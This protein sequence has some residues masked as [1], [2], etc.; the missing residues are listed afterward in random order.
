MKEENIFKVILNDILIWHI[1]KNINF[2][3]LITTLLD[4]DYS[5]CIRKPKNMCYLT[6]SGTNLFTATS[7]TSTTT[8]STTAASASTFTSRPEPVFHNITSNVLTLRG[9]S[10]TPFRVAEEYCTD[11]GYWVTWPGSNRICS[12]HLERL[13]TPIT[14]ESINYCIVIKNLGLF[15]MHTNF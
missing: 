10:Q 6:L 13:L 14:S 1:I 12:R 9:R 7:T 15:L 5:V 2:K 3:K 11:N 8:P 4:I